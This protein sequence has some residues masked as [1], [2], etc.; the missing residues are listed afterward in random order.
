MK[1]GLS[2]PIV[3]AA[4]ENACLFLVY[5][6]IQRL[7]DGAAGVGSSESDGAAREK[8]LSE[9]ALAAAGAGAVTSFVLCVSSYGWWRALDLP[10]NLGGERRDPAAFSLTSLPPPC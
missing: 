3:G 9:L 8:P 5:N 4:A 7:V 1:Q 6:Q 10:L 2:A